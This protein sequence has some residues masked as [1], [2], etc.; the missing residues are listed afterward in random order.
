MSCGSLHALVCQAPPSG[1]SVWQLL[2]SRANLLS[3]AAQLPPCGRLRPCS[4][5]GIVDGTMAETDGLSC[6]GSVRV[7]PQQEPNRCY[8]SVHWLP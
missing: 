3:A 7:F 2:G 8:S 5:R 1:L 6:L 4:R